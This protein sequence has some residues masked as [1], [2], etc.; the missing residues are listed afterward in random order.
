MATRRFVWLA[1]VGL[2]LS[3]AGAQTPSGLLWIEA[4]NTAQRNFNPQVSGWGNTQFLSGGSWAT[5]SIPADR[6]NVD[7]PPNG[8]LLEYR[9]PVTKPGRYGI[10]NRIGMEFVR[11][12]FEWQIDNGPFTTVSPEA[13]TTDL[14]E[15]A[16]WNEVAWLKLGDVTLS[17]GDHKLTIRLPQTKDKDG[18]PARV[19]YSSD[20]ICLYPGPREFQPHGKHKPGAPW[21]SE[22]DDAA[23][24]QVFKV[25]VPTVPGARATVKL[26]GDWEVCRFDE[27]LP[28]DDIAVPIKD[29]PAAPYWS[30]IPVPSD[31]NVS[32]PDLVFCH[33][34]W[35]RTR[36]EV[37]PAL[38]GRSFQVVF[39]QNNLN[40]TVRLNGTLCGFNKNPFAKFSID[41]SAAVRPGVNELW[42]GLRDAW[43]GYTN[44]PGDPLALRRKFNLP[45]SFGSAGF[46][47]LAYPIWN[48]FQSGILVAPELICGGSTYVSDVFCQ[49]SVADHALGLEVTLKNPTQRPAQGE[50]RCEAVRVQTGEVERR[51]APQPVNLSG[52]QEQVLKLRESWPEATLWWPDDPQMYRLRTTVVVGGKP[53][54][55]LE[56]PFGFREWG[57]RGKDFTLNGLVWHGWAD[58]H[59]AATKEAWLEH[60]RRSNQKM[61]RFWGTS[62]Q[63][64]PP[65]EALDWFDQQGVPVRRSGILDGEAIGYFA[66]EQDP[67]LRK[68]WGSEVKMDLMRNWQDQLCAQVRGERNHPSVMLW[69]IENE[70]L[71]INCINLYG[72]LMDDFEKVVT[73]VSNAVRAV[74]PTRATM[75]DGGGATKAQSL[76]VHGDHYVFSPSNTGYP[77]LAYE[78][79]VTGGGRGRWQWDQQ[80][81]RFLG[82]DYFA[83][84][85][86]PADYAI[87][88]GEEAF[89][90][91]AQARPAAGIIFRMLT[92][93]YR[94]AEY[95]AWQFW[96]GQHE[97]LEQYG[98][99]AW[100]AVFCRQWDWTFASG[101]TVPRTLRIFNDTRFSDPLTLTW[102]LSVGGA[103]VAGES[104]EHAVPPG[105]SVTLEPT[106]KLPNVTDR[107]A[108][109]L[110]LTLAAKRAQVFRDVKPLAVLPPPTA[111]VAGKLI[112]AAPAGLEVYDPAG[113]VRAWLTARALPHRV[114]ESLEAVTPTAPLLLL[115]RNSLT[116]REAT[117]SRLAAWAAAG[118]RVIVL[119]QDH[120][121]RYQGLP[122]EMEATASDGRLAF[123]ED[124]GHPLLRGLQPPDF[125]TWAPDER[126]YRNAYAKPTR[127]AKSL[128]QAGPRLQHSLL[129]EV[130]CGQGLLLVCQMLVAEKLAASPVAAQLLLNLLTTASEYKLEYRQVVAAVADAPPLAAAL[131]AIGLKYQ[132]TADPLTALNDPAVGLVLLAATPARLQALAAAQP[133]VEAF[134]ARGGY[135]VVCGLTP[136]GLGAYNKL[137][138]YE[139]LIR[140]FRMERVQFSTPR[141]PLTAGITTGD[142]VQLSGERIF[143]WTSDEFVSKEVFSH[144]VD[145]D[146]VAPFA[147]FPSDYHLNTVNG[148][149]S[150]DAWKYIFSFEKPSEKTPAFTM[151]WPTEQTLVQLDWI[152]NGFYHLVSQLQ[153]SMDLQPPRTIETVPNNEPQ[154]FELTPPLVGKA[155][156]L[157]VSKWQVTPGKGEVVG[158]DNLWLKA[159]RPAGFYERVK[160]LLNVGGLLDY[161]R[162]RGGLLLCN[163]KFAETEAVPVNK[164]KKQRILAALLRNLQAPFAGGGAVIAGAG[165][166]YEPVDLSKSCNQFRNE[167]GWFG[168]PQTS[169]ADLPTGRQ[170]FAGVQYEVYEFPTSPVPNAVMLGGPRVPG[171]L[172]AEVK[173]IPVGK[174]ADALF[175]LHAARLDARRNDREKRDGKQYELAHYTVTYADGQTA[176][177]PVLA[178]TDVEEYRQ[179]EPAAV[180]GAQLAWT[181]PYANRNQSAVA[182]SFQWTNPR[183]EVEI[184]SLT[185]T[186]A[187]PRR[188]VLALL[189]LTTAR[190]LA[191]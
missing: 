185:L 148:F 131:G 98:S 17:A 164:L 3:A 14:M 36:F 189:A 107:T 1:T 69:S 12:V 64:L 177:V 181:K 187:E 178:E 171:N 52:G 180:P 81:P 75:V 147:E 8:V 86:N 48:H 45:V 169:F 173:D 101:A 97:A 47:P 150:A 74:D 92:E 159:K 51:L 44:K 88:G 119:E 109:E 57:A 29:L 83:N 84:G 10:W 113:E 168:D 68:L 124:L 34:L 67:D 56:T 167:K 188:G 116:A 21:R 42:V 166:T 59:T 121:L 117:S 128:V 149:V 132:P 111:P 133:Q 183:P 89:G 91:K 127:G 63:G 43:Y 20:L 115:G 120:P 27:Q 32:R 13:L 85:I 163:L 80:R 191:P 79:N 135:L 16:T 118:K 152:G 73:D 38:V 179:A 30:A 122:A 33:R 156:E 26:A 71:Y 28:G 62:W 58:C 160:P 130:P 11:S 129:A 9:L 95:G 123:P 99:N 151:K 25:P 142:I 2:L 162:G 41:L 165:L 155:L 55:S 19:L 90:G 4:E 49:P 70:W 134:W 22:A 35:Y 154:S 31:K 103:K 153:L 170:T 138:G 172:P 184:R 61:M 93:G 96:M 143:G 39:P 186:A 112:A 126:V 54:D 144:C 65:A 175:F 137:V 125:F 87:F 157:K 104:S 5:V 141:H 145:Y 136:E 102:T 18:K 40:T 46:Q 158:I 110:V 37:P 82:E 174:R 100:R 50:L 6:L 7:L 23:A 161:P 190:Q 139:H 76:P 146:D 53:V 66:V 77:A 72:R 108:G 94:W 15:L 140:P 78:P 114:V 176:T 182:Y 60:Y 24:K 106:L 105:G